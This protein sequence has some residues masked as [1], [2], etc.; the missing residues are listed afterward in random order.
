MAD[1]RSVSVAADVSELQA[2]LA[3]AKADVRAFT[4]ETSK[5]ASTIRAG[6][7]AS[8]L[9][10]GQL[11]QVA[12][13]AVAAKSNVASL[14]AALR[15]HRAANDNTVSGVQA[16]RAA[17]ARWG[18]TATSTRE[19]VVGTFEKIQTGF[20]ALNGLLAGGALFGEAIRDVIQLDEL[21]IFGSG[22]SRR[23]RRAW[24]RAR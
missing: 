15:D 17:F 22:R 19:Q 1:N 24:R 7:D 12:G 13:Q 8:G 16:V 9:L 23:H 10:R 3:L 14:T 5:L 18:E 2:Q 4:T 21:A 11:E 6:G 20:L